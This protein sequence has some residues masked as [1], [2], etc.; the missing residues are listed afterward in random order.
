MVFVHNR[1]VLRTGPGVYTARS[2]EGNMIIYHAVVNNSAVDICIVYYCAVYVY[3]RCVVTEMTARPHSAVEAY[4]SVAIAIINTTV[5]A[6]VGAPIALVETISATF[7]SPISW[8][9]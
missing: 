1:Q 5:K 4:T 6:Y 7:I 8:S 2:V 3:N 9:P